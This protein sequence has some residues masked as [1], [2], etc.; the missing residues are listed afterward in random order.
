MRSLI[1]AVCAAVVVLFPLRAAAQDPLHVD[2]PRVTIVVNDPTL[3]GDTMLKPGQYRFQCRHVDGKTF[4]VISQAESGKEIFRVPCA[5]ESVNG[6][7]VNT[8]LRALVQ[9][10]GTR[11][12]QSVRIKGETIAHRVIG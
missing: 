10:D 6:K 5:Q 11:V 2:S 3:V 7:I 4:L 12:L 1:F 9:P 8:E